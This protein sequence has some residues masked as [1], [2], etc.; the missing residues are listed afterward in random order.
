MK[1]IIVLIIMA[2]MMMFIGFAEE[3]MDTVMSLTE[4]ENAASVHLLEKLGFLAED[5][6]EISGTELV[7]YLK[8]M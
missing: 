3:G 2:S 6:V 7:R 5:T 8:K 1:R 4:R